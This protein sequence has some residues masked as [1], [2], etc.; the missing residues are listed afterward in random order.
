[1]A[2]LPADE[3]LPVMFV[4]LGCSQEFL[5]VFGDLLSF[6][7]DVFGAGEAGAWGHGGLCHIWYRAIALPRHTPLPPLPA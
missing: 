6:P 2:A 1:M 7:D 4:F 5:D 3:A